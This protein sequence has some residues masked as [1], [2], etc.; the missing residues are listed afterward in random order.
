MLF[1][2]GSCGTAAG[3]VTAAVPES[4]QT[5]KVLPSVTH[6]AEGRPVDAGVAAPLV[7][8]P[9]LRREEFSRFEQALQRTWP[10]TASGQRCKPGYPLARFSPDGT[11][12]AISVPTLGLK[13]ARRVWLGRP[14]HRRHLEWP[15][16]VYRSARS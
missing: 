8:A 7:A 13:E 9:V 1:F 5:A 6:R 4:Q 2:S 3:P 15:T 11:Q 10:T 14:R 12:L 16:L